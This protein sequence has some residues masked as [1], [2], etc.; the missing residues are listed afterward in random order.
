MSPFVLSALMPW[1]GDSEDHP[2]LCVPRLIDGRWIATDGTSVAWCAA[3]DGDAD[4]MPKHKGPDC[5]DLLRNLEAEWPTV[6]DWR[7]KS[8]VNDIP[9]NVLKV[10]HD[11]LGIGFLRDEDG[12]GK[13]VGARLLIPC[14]ACDGK[15]YLQQRQIRFDFQGTE[16]G[17]SIRNLLKI[18]PAD[19][20]AV[21]DDH[22]KILVMSH[23][24]RALIMPMELGGM[25]RNA[26]VFQTKVDACKSVPAR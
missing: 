11:C 23:R 4:P 5:T 18:R 6:K 3:E 24:Y 21:A 22:R 26:H 1:C 9:E 20:I 19:H 8:S 10:C 14:D 25:A 12:D 15:C 16:R 7:L 2:L 13:P 17:I